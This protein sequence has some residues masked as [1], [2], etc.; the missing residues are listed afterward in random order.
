MNEELLENKTDDEIKDYI[1][2][3]L[4]TELKAELR[5]EIKYEVKDMVKK[6]LAREEVQEVPVAINDSSAVNKVS[7]KEILKNLF[8]KLNKKAALYAAGAFAAI[9]VIVTVVL[10]VFVFNGWVVKDGGYRYYRYGRAASGNSTID[11]I[12]YIFNED[13]LLYEGWISYNGAT[14]YQDFANG[15]YKNESVI[16]GVSYNIA[17]DGTLTIG[18]VIKDG[19]TYLYDMQGYSVTG[20]TLINDDYYFANDEGLIVFGWQN[21]NGDD[22]YFDEETGIMA[23]GMV[24]I[25]GKNWYFNENGVRTYGFVDFPEG[26]RYFM[27]GGNYAT[28]KM[29]IVNDTY[30]F[31]DNGI[32]QTGFVT[33]DDKEYYFAE[34]TGAMFKGW[35]L[36]GNDYC[37]Y[38]DNG[39]KAYGFTVIEDKY[40]YFDE[41]TGFMV[42]G[43]QNIDNAD[44]YF[45]DSGVMAVG[46][47]NISGS[48]Y[49]FD[50]NGK[51]ITG[52]GWYTQ[53]NK[54]YYRLGEGKI[55]TGFKDMNGA[56][57][58]FA[59]DGSL[60]IGMTK[61]GDNQYYFYNDGTMARNTK[62]DKFDVDANGVLTNPFATITND[63]LDAYV[64]LLLDT[65]GR[66]PESI[67]K[68]CRNNFY[69]KY[70]D[71]SDVNSMAC[72]MI[73]NGCGACW[74][75]AALCYKMLK[76]AGYNCQIVVGKG[77]FYAEHNWIIM[78]V[79]PGVWRHLDPERTHMWVYMKTDADLEA[80]DGSAR[81]I[82]YQWDHSKYPA[83][84]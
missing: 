13:K 29:S 33:Y 3:T 61:I 71:K 12:E 69:Y 84:K 78:E 25:E 42:K 16:N 4:K 74:D 45:D 58:H 40:H 14:Y 52:D 37:Y 32:M 18:T 2:E 80:L 1:K 63:N 38:D 77:A 64:Q 22:Y 60:S 70:R 73:N 72:R 66:D 10:L 47:R 62:I 27:A 55:A 39:V 19:G 54:K 43:W 48:V 20:L 35:M 28:G 6:E 81:G 30:Y 67:Y 68:Y 9:A 8:A 31:D 15:V 49:L 57:Y 7:V 23:V 79:S 34:D 50:G 36:L 83:A 75:Y 26:R 53:G 46:A 21:F 44:R 5:A 17:A 59:S 51:L 76:A 56:T 65:Y 82:R 41:E 24:P 11:G